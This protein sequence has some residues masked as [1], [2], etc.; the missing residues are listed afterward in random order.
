MQIFMEKS[1]SLAAVTSWLLSPPF[2]HQSSELLS[3]KRE[4]TSSS[5]ICQASPSLPYTHAVAENLCVSPLSSYGP[6]ASFLGAAFWQVGSL[7]K[8]LKSPLTL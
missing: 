2:F 5:S 6:S 1:W 4:A 8:A 7:W 3:A